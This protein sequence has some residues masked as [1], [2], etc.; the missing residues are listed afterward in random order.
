MVNQKAFNGVVLAVVHRITAMPD[1]D[2]RKMRQLKQAIKKRGT[3][4]RRAE[5]KLV[6]DAKPEAAH[7]HE[8]TL[9]RYRSAALNGLDKDSTRCR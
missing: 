8:E 2:K 3:K 5:F 4:H 1:P 6:L 9:G 7:E